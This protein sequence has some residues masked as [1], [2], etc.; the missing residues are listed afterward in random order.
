[1]ISWLAAH[2]S[3]RKPCFT[4]TRWS[5]PQVSWGLPS[6]LAATT[7]YGHAYLACLDPLASH[8]VNKSAPFPD[9]KY[10]CLKLLTDVYTWLQAWNGASVRAVEWVGSRFL[11]VADS[12]CCLSLWELAYDE[13]REEISMRTIASV[14]MRTADAGGL[15]DD[16]QLQCLAWE[17][18]TGILAVGDSAGKISLFRAD[19]DNLARAKMDGQTITTLPGLCPNKPTGL[20]GVQ[21][22]HLH[23]SDGKGEQGWIVVCDGQNMAYLAW[24]DFDSEARAEGRIQLEAARLID[25]PHTHSFNISAASWD[26][27][28]TSDSERVAGRWYSYGVD[29]RV[30]R[31]APRSYHSTTG[32]QCDSGEVPTILP[33]GERGEAQNLP[34]LG[35]DVLDASESVLAV[36]R[37]LPSVKDNTRESQLNAALS[38]CRLRLDFVP[39]PGC[40]WWTD[41]ELLPQMIEQLRTPRRP[42]SLA[43]VLLSVLAIVATQAPTGN[44]DTRGNGAGANG[45]GGAAEHGTDNAHQHNDCTVAASSNA[46]AGSMDVGTILARFRRFAYELEASAGAPD[47]LADWWRRTLGLQV[48]HLLTCMLPKFIGVV[49][50]APDADFSVDDDLRARRQRLLRS[51]AEVLAGQARSA[52]PAPMREAAQRMSQA[53]SSES[54]RTSISPG[55]CPICSSRLAFDDQNP[56]TVRCTNDHVFECCM[57]SFSVIDPLQTD[58]QIFQC[59]VCQSCAT[60]Q[61]M[62]HVSSLAGLCIFCS[63]QLLRVC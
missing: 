63:V 41:D 28:A 26:L 39:G 32:M 36:A 11:A 8:L 21:R 55:N 46:E 10:G 48:D 47:P 3:Q 23:P 6:I 30:L 44:R 12:T 5:P 52:V 58:G 15:F 54:A 9:V 35:L 42:T 53:L 37:L 33:R 27:Q 14:D 7:S 24:A 51:Y 2:S 61:A 49:G 45:N 13:P 4:S 50:N 56:L 40:A 60:A 29:G 59:P 57:Y 18:S 38:Y 25:H 19:M 22:I 62:K 34:V 31:W 43:S 16:R 17:E 1:M 20:S